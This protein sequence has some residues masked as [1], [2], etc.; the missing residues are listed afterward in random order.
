MCDQEKLPKTSGLREAAPSYLRVTDSLCVD[1]SRLV[2]QPFHH[3][4]EQEAPKVV[5]GSPLHFHSTPSLK[6][7]SRFPVNCSLFPI[8]FAFLSKE[9]RSFCRLTS[10]P[11]PTAHST[12][13]RYVLNKPCQESPTS[14]A[15]FSDCLLCPEGL[16]FHL[17]PL[18][19]CSFL[20]AQVQCSL[21]PLSTKLSLLS[22]TQVTLPC[23]CANVHDL[24]FCY[25]SWHILSVLK[26]I[27]KYVSSLEA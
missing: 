15:V 7:R 1:S 11:P 24:N 3:R 10:L 17:L 22:Q 21:S 26:V 9:S 12:S 27:C 5:P 19:S 14:R 13:T 20:L 18:K 4:P 25:G 2:S 8:K 16:C 23:L 6:H